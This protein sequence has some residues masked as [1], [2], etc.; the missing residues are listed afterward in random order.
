MSW[1]FSLRPLNGEGECGL[2][3]GPAALRESPEA[4]LERAGA[5][6]LLLKDEERDKDALVGVWGIG[7]EAPVGFKSSRW[8]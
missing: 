5:A 2:E 1:E 6:R 4:R 8:R 3:G 7:K